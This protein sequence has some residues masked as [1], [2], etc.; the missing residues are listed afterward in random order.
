MLREVGIPAAGARD[1]VELVRNGDIETVRRVRAA[2]RVVG[3]AIADLV[4]ILNPRVIALS[5]MLAECDENLMSG[6]RERVYQRA[7]P[8]VTRDLTIARSTLGEHAGVIGLAYIVSDE[9][10]RPSSL[11]RILARTTVRV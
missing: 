8:L 3:D 9:V 5:G 2:G 6:I 10:L 7:T 1:I 4:S 11:D